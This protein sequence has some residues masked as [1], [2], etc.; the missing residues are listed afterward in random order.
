MAGDTASL[1]PEWQEALEG[2]SDL[3]SELDREHIAQLNPSPQIELETGKPSSDTHFDSNSPLLRIHRAM[4][5][6]IVQPNMP[7]YEV[8]KKL[9]SD[10]S[11]ELDPDEMHIILRYLQNFFAD[12]SQS[13]ESSTAI[14]HELLL[15]YIAADNNDLFLKEGIL[16]SDNLGNIINVACK[17]KKFDWAEQF[18]VKHKNIIIGERSESQRLMDLCRATILFEQ[19]RYGEVIQKIGNFLNPIFLGY[20]F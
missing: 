3:Q 13:K 9:F 6:L 17:C 11:R 18:I 14:Y 20:S 12:Q 7:N 1:N 15:L 19:T 8:A 10:H 4:H 16:V 5:K 2:F